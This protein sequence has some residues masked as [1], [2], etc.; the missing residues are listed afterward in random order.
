MTG[1]EFCIF[2]GM[3]D[4]CVKQNVFVGVGIR[5]RVGLFLCAAHRDSGSRGEHTSDGGEV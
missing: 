4:G 5:A 1:S 2:F 3:A